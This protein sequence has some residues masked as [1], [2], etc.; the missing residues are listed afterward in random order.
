MPD[1]PPEAVT[2][3]AVAIR[4]RWA[5]LPEPFDA[6]ALAIAALEAAAPHLATAQ[7]EHD[8]QLAEER[9]AQCPVYYGT[10]L[11][12]W[13]PFAALLRQGHAAGTRDTNE[14]ELPLYVPVSG[15]LHRHG[16]QDKGWREHSHLGGG[17]PHKHAPDTDGQVELRQG[18]AAGGDT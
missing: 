9:G 16:M 11:T 6:G 14:T 13:Q 10:T 1:L 12:A 18:H 7:R 2:A 5:M 17:A 15:F 8:A 3:A 4:K